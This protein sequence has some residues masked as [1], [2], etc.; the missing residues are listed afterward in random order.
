MWLAAKVV[1]SF[2]LPLFGK[3]GLGEIFFFHAAA[4]LQRIAALLRKTLLTPH[5]IP[6]NP[7]FPKGESVIASY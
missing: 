5:Q 4:P 7:S 6:L 1:A 3:E 2:P